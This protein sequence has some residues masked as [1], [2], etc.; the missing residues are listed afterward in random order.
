MIKDTNMISISFQRFD[1]ALDI[2]GWTVPSTSLDSMP[3]DYASIVTPQKPDVNPA[4]EVKGAILATFGIQ[5][6]LRV[7]YC[8]RDEI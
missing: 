3:M 5:V 1:L 7:H 2:V 8:K 6:S 4:S